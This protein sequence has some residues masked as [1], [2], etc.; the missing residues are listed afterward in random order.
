MPQRPDIKDLSLKALELFQL[1]ARRG[2]LQAVATETGLSPSTVSH[3]LRNL[4]GSLRV[5][6]IDHSRRPLVLTPKGKVFLRNIDDALHALRKA[7]AEAA[8]GDTS[9]ASFL[10]VGAIEDFD[11]DVIPSLAVSLFE[12]MPKCDFVYHTDSS[13]RI[14]EM[15]KN[16]DLDI[17]I[18]ATSN[19]RFPDCVERP[20]LRDPFVMVLPK[21]L[22][23][24]PAEVLNGKT[25]L[26]FLRFS[27][28]LVIARQIE[29]QLRRIN[30][31]PAHRFECDNNQTLLAMVAAGTGWA[32]TTPLLF[33]RARRFHTHIEMHRFPGKGFARTL[34]VLANDDCSRSVL[35]LVETSVR[36]LIQE[37]LIKP[38]QQNA[39]WLAE[40]FRLLD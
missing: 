12:S 34:A 2:S 31:L 20:L 25:N 32:V 15:L 29:A 19:E 39:S 9:D 22:E 7:R 16:R 13:H 10:R 17:G 26:P 37:K 5:Q 6:L 8:V 23:W 11:S 21:S 4:E 24:P 35:D 30:V 18:T 28:N 3:H 14:V 33:S 27:S 38:T 1:C 40:S 36:D